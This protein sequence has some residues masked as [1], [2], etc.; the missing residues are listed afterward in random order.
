MT[1]LSIISA[2][3]LISSS[4]L[5]EDSAATS[6]SAAFFST[7]PSVGQVDDVDVPR[8][9]RLVEHHGF[10]LAPTFGVTTLNHD[11]APMLGVRGAWLANNTFGV[12][13]SFNALANQTDEKLHYK[14]RA[15]SGY[16]GLLL[17]YLI[18]ADHVVHGSIDTMIGG[19]VACLQTGDQHEDDCHGRRFFA[20]EPMANLEISVFSGMRI[21]LGAGYR[22]AVAP[23]DSKLTSSEIGGFVSKAALQFGR[24]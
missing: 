15:L 24:F 13:F 5:A 9:G 18:G 14:G 10:Y 11:V 4:A 8:R 16:G 17:Q 7:A 22:L 12:G 2:L 19:G 1:K 23:S 20:L 3:L 21:S 6:L